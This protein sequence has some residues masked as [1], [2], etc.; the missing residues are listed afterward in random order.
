MYNQRTIKEVV[1]CVGIGLH[2]GK[3]VTLRILPAPVDTGV[4]FFRSDLPGHPCVKAS[5]ENVIDTS[6]ATT[7]GNGNASVSTIEH[8]MASFA[9][10]GI[11]NVYVEVDSP[12]LPIMDGS[13]APF[14]FLIKSGGIEVQNAFKRF[15]MVRN[16]VK[17]GS[18]ESYI[19]ISPARELRLSCTIDFDHP[20]IRKQS[21]DIRFSDTVF[22]NELSRAR[23]FCLLK[24]VD[25]LKASGLIKGGSLD[26][27]LVIDDFKV[28][29]EGELRYKN[30]FVRHKMLDVIGDM[31]LLGMP[32]IGQITAYRPGHSLNH[33]VTREIF[34][35]PKLCK[36]VDLNEIS[37]LERSLSDL[38]LPQPTHSSVMA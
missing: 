30:E 10:L 3:K 12:E 4:V 20:M 21:F 23:T 14:V 38:R 32:V 11:D 7:I 31:A 15:L 26:N 13:A 19:S 29:N 17:I 5:V 24:E 28:L 22:E 2:T 9:G 6:Y 34:S 16:S 37:D 27:A 18:R 8:L 25:A 1:E 33:T 35:N 36:V